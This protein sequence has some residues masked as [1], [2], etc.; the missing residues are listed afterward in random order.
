MQR[1]DSLRLLQ[2]ETLRICCWR[3]PMMSSL[4]DVRWQ[5]VEL[6]T[7]LSEQLAAPW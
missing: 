2:G 6:Q 5:N 1:G 4:V 3:L 7:G